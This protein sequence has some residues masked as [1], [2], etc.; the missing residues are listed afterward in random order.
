MKA[1]AICTQ[2]MD[3][4]DGLG[5]ITSGNN[6]KLLDNIQQKLAYKGRYQF[7]KI[8]RKWM[9]DPFSTNGKLSWCYRLRNSPGARRVLFIILLM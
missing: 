4:D 6:S 8:Y 3:T 5:I 2:D 7:G 1:H 9:P